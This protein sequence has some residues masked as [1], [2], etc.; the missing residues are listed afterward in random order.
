MDEVLREQKIITRNVENIVERLHD[1]EYDQMGDNWKMVAQRLAKEIKRNAQINDGLLDQISLLS[2]FNGNDEDLGKAVFELNDVINNDLFQLG[3]IVFATTGIIAFAGLS[4]K[5]EKWLSLDTS[6]PRRPARK[7]FGPRE[8]TVYDILHEVMQTKR[9]DETFLQDDLV[10]D[11]ETVL[12][13]D[14]VQ[15][16]VSDKK[17]MNKGQINTSL[18]PEGVKQKQPIAKT[19][20]PGGVD[21][22]LSQLEEL[23]RDKNEQKVE[24]RTTQFAGTAQFPT[25]EQRMSQQKYLHQ[26]VN[27]KAYDEKLG[28]YNSVLNQQ[29][30]ISSE[31]EKAMAMNTLDKKSELWRIE[32]LN[33]DLQALGTQFGL[34]V[35]SDRQYKKAKKVPRLSQ[36]SS[37]L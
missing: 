4:D 12:Q 13:D 5:L 6:T 29:N 22:R 33:S 36:Q 23:L 37:W 15:D 14:L 34:Q 7:K 24:Q 21:Q 30:Q 31:I 1:G 19:D 27:V 17:E 8:E 18:V 2:D 28:N 10:P 16:D 25:N 35:P 3:A 32:R 26:D 11:D 9:D 20:E